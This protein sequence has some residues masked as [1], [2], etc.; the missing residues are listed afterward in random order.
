MKFQSLTLANG[1]IGILSGPY[2]GKRHDS[3]MLHWSGLLTNLQRSAWHNIQPLCIYGDPGYPLSIH[4]QQVP[5][6]PKKKNLLKKSETSDILKASCKSFSMKFL[7]V[8]S[9]LRN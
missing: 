2:E 9:F 1:A 4:L 7:E 5:E 6:N 3:T 8:N